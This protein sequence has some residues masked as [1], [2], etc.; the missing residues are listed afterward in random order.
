MVL[1]M[2]FLDLKSVGGRDKKIILEGQ[3][4]KKI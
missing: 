3:P 2:K 4:R 1:Q